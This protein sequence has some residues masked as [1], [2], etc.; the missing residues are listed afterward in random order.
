MTNFRRLAAG[1]A[2]GAL[3]TSFGA[4]AVHAQVTTGAIQGVAVGV[5]GKPVAGATVVAL[6]VPSGIRVTTVTNA[7]G[8]FDFRGLR[9]GGPYRVT[10]SAPNY[11][12]QQVDDIYLAV[13]S[14]ER[15]TLTLAN[16]NTVE[17]IVVRASAKSKALVADEGTRTTIRAQAIE[18]VVTPRR[19]LRDVA[20]RSPLAQ[21]D[22]VTRGTGPTGGL[23]IAG[24]LPRSNRIT[25]DGVRSQDDFGLNT[26]GL[27]TNR[28]PISLE[29]VEQ[30]SIQAAPFDVEEGDF[31]GGALNLITKAGGNRFHGEV[32]GFTRTGRDV[33]TQLPFSAITSDAAGNLIG[34]SDGL[35]KVKNK[36]HESNEGVFLS[37]PIWK[38]HIFFAGSYERY[39]SFDITGAGPAGQGFATLFNP[40]PGISTGPNTTAADIAS[41]T[42]LFNNYAASKNL[43]PGIVSPTFPVIDEKYSGRLDWD[44]T[45]GQRLTATYRRAFSSVEKARSSSTTGIFLDTNT[46]AQPELENNYAIQLNSTWTPEFSTEG[47]VSYRKYSRGQT[48]PEGQAFSQFTVC[49][50]PTSNILTNQYA[51]SSG[52]PSVTFGPD[53]FRQ[54]NVLRTSDLAGEFVAN[55]RFLNNHLIKLGYQYKGIDIYDLFVQQAHGVYYFDSVADF[56]AGRPN[57][58]QYGNAFSGNP[59]DAAA[60]LKYQVHSLFAQDSF[61]ITPNL[62]VNYG[63]R[64][65]LYASGSAPLNNPNFSGR[66]GFTNQKTF[67]GLGVLMP[68][69]SFKY[70]TNA[71]EASGGIGLVSGGLPDVFITNSFGANTGAATNAI[72]IRRVTD[73]VTKAVTFIEAN[74]NTPIDPVTGASILNLD[75]TNAS[76]ASQPAAT[77]QA[78][79][80]LDSANRRLAYT[81][82]LALNF[83][84]PS[85]W[86]ANLSLKTRQFGVD[87]EIDALA[88]RSNTNIAFRDLRARLLTQNGQ[89]LLTPDG[90]LRYDGLNISAAQRTAL[91]LPVSANPDLVNVG[92]TGDIQAYNPNVD[93]TSETLAFSIG[94]DWH[95]FDGNVTYVIQRGRSLIGISEFGTT[96][97]G[98]STS[99]NYYAD[100]TFT[101]DP[102]GAAYGKLNN[103]IDQGYKVNLS[104]K[105]EFYPGFLSRIT[106]FGETH[107]GRPLN[108]LFTDPTGNR[109]P[110]FGVSRDDALAYIPNLSAPTP[111]S[112]LHFTSP[113]GTTV[114]FADQKTLTSFTQLVNRFNIPQGGIVPRGVGRNPTVSRID[115]Q[116]AQ[117]VPVPY[118]HDHKVVL[119]LDIANL[120]NLIDHT[121]GVIKEYGGSRAGV[122]IVNAQCADAAGKLPGNKAPTSSTPVCAS[123]LYSY[124]TVN[125]ASAATAT[126]DTNT[127]YSVVF[128]VKYKF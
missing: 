60:K 84:I 125:A 43:T 10:A 65:D 112:P 106:L 74:T 4:A 40:I 69:F 73:P 38:D 98:N 57:Q 75:L 54:A 91:G 36:I 115:F 17:E 58:L 28:G 11:K 32:F 26:G 18:T 127:L 34:P 87:F 29:A 110:T 16:A 37:G 100:Q 121:W 42:G 7:G 50:D 47:R 80:N 35:R 90:R 27:S 39:D 113:S 49:G 24:S 48:P 108:F 99:G 88:T 81:N 102:N 107:T 33:G 31:T 51:C 109:N 114:F 14:E 71:F 120:G 22:N 21:L 66:Y 45:D 44:I 9:V 86:K 111:G 82:S 105:H 76:L 61:D 72:N 12:L 96:E 67:D 124:A 94:K 52:V 126:I 55:Y 56:A 53:Q 85:D 59:V 123:Y 83:E 128:G 5:D 23:Y 118:L 8:G 15:V 78:L 3:A 25:I 117:E 41:V 97:G 30:V 119:T 46:Y 19:D 1:V 93:N 20:R 13:A 79:L 2:L 6:N 101:T 122:P 70:R 116:F 104:W 64:Y 62:T 89:Q 77:A 63:L 103:E 92:L 68:R 95:D